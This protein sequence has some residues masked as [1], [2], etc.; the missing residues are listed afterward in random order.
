M[1]S[2]VYIH[3]NI[4][5]LVMHIM[6]ASLKLQPGKRLVKI[7]LH[8]KQVETQEIHQ[9]LSPSNSEIILRELS[10]S[11]DWWTMD[12]YQKIIYILIYSFNSY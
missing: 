1:C 8:G 2:C 9:K 3:I 7:L 4:Y 12:S 10:F 6:E 11:R 5:I